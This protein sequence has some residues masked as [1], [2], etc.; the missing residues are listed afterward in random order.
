MPNKTVSYRR[1]HRID[2]IYFRSDLHQVP[3]VKSPANFATELYKQY[4][5]DISVLLDISMP[6][7]CLKLKRN[8]LLNDS[9][10]HIVWPRHRD[11]SLSMHG[12]NKKNQLLCRLRQQIAQCIC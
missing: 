9:L 10:S 11:D 8:R 6:H 4:V 12:A 3:F 5:H 7:L 2:M 1:Y